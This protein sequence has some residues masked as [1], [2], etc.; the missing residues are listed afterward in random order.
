[1]RP[2]LPALPNNVDLAR[3]VGEIHRETDQRRKDDQAE[4]RA[5]E[6]AHDRGFAGEA[7]AG[8]T[9]A[10]GLPPPSRAVITCCRRSSARSTEIRSRAIFSHGPAAS[11]AAPV[12]PSMAATAPARSPR[13]R[14]A[15]AALTAAS[16]PVCGAPPTLR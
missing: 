12:R 15:R 6:A 9:G 4:N 10:E 13:S 7:S 8:A 16:G 3:A 5:D 1:R 14:E 2:H 11:A